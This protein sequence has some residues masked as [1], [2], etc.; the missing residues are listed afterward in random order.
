[1]ETMIFFITVIVLLNLL[2]S[3]SSLIAVLAV[4]TFLYKWGNRLNTPP[5]PAPVVEQPPLRTRPTLAN[6]PVTGVD[7]Y[8]TGGVDNLGT[9]APVPQR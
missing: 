8:A 3:V 7:P 5:A 2:V 9:V 4:G 6:G 1:M